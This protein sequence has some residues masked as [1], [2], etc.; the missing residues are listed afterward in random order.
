LVDLAHAYIV[1]LSGTY[2][3]IFGFSGMAATIV[4]NNA[5]IV[6]TRADSGVS[7]IAGSSIVLRDIHI[8]EP[9]G[10]VVDGTGW[11]TID[12]SKLVVDNMESDTKNLSPIYGRGGDTVTIRRSNFIGSSVFATRLVA[13][14]CFFHNGG[15]AVAGSIELTNSVVIADPSSSSGLAIRI[16]STVTA[17]SNSKVLNNTF[18]GG[19]VTCSMPGLLAQFTNNIFY[20]HTSIDVSNNCAYSTTW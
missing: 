14:T 10:V 13:D 11:I 1:L 18:V 19:Q 6:F 4:G 3:G 12:S 17:G 5:T 2:E 15:P 8:E 7:I 9:S 20:N 16:N